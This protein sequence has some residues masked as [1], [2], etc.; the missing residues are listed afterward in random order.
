MLRRAVNFVGFTIWLYIVIKAKIKLHGFNVVKGIAIL[1]VEQ[2]C[3][4]DFDGGAP[5]QFLPL[6]S[7]TCTCIGC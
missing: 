6:V 1:G 5:G 2:A 4:I 3:P 7:T